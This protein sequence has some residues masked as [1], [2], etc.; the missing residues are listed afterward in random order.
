MDF[1]A[2]NLFHSALF[3]SFFSTFLA[4]DIPVLFSLFDRDLNIVNE[5]FSTKGMV[6]VT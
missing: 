1:L 4:R 6:V 3:F 2:P 5:C